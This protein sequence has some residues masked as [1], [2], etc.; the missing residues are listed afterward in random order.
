MD[1]DAPSLAPEATL[2]IDDASAPEGDV[3]TF[4]VTLDGEVPGGFTATPELTDGTATSGEDYRAEPQSVRFAGS[5]GESHVFSIPTVDD[6]V[7]EGDETFTVS[8]VVSG[9]DRGGDGDGHRH[10]PDRGRRPRAGR[11][12]GGTVA[13]LGDGR[14][15]RHR[16]DGS[17][18]ERGV[19]VEGDSGACHR[20]RR[21]RRGGGGSRLHRIARVVHGDDSGGL[22][23]GIVDVLARPRK[24]HAAGDRRG[25][26]VER[27]IG[28]PPRDG[29]RRH[30]GGR[31]RVV[32]ASGRPPG[33]RRAA[34]DRGTDAGDGARRDR[35]RDGDGAAAGDDE[36]GGQRRYRAVDA[37]LRAGRHLHGADTRRR[38][39]GERDVHALSDRGRSDRRQRDADGDRGGVP[40]GGG[41]G[42]GDD[43]R[44]GPGGGAGRRDGSHVVPAGA[45]HRVGG[46]GRDRGTF[47]G[48]GPRPQGAAGAHAA[49]RSEC[50]CRLDGPVHR[51]GGFVRRRRHAR[52]GPGHAG[53]G[54]RR[55][56]GAGRRFGGAVRRGRGSRSGRPG[57]GHEHA[58]AA[59]AVRQ[60]RVARRGQLRRA[61]GR[62]SGRRR[63]AGRPGR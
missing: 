50:G 11:P 7:E 19:L 37:R 9:H 12:E 30:A 48:R 17:V 31:R 41:V 34:R 42:P 43:S 10:G 53:H 35:R 55:A 1:D 25:L 51:C 14:V 21:V 28:V 13:R 32:G 40:A 29:D 56:G 45:R 54:G 60:A 27:H 57:H 24:R 38:V 5:A 23:R 58:G 52:G 49:P 33:T 3:L 39:A 8:L 4:A 18:R 15:D 63:D 20:G 22:G 47:H 2:T 26:D 61:P 62:R 46:A 36:R 44:R 59:A 6:A 16:G